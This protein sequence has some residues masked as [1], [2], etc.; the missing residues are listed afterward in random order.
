[1]REIVNCRERKRKLNRL[2]LIRLW[3]LCSF[4]VCSLCLCARDK[5]SS[6]A[7]CLQAALVCALYSDCDC[8]IIRKREMIIGAEVKN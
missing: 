3:Q 5:D 4:E 2:S 1:M 8:F 7:I 6:R